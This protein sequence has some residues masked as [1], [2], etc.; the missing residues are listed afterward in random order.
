MRWQ[1]GNISFRTVLFANV[2][3]SWYDSDVVDIPKYGLDLESAS[4]C[5]I[6][7]IP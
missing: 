2:M 4:E 1:T 3:F 5:I 7:H 6:R